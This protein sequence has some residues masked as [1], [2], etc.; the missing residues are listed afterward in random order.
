MHG[1][2]LMSFDKVLKE[3]EVDYIINEEFNKDCIYNSD[4]GWFDYMVLGGRFRGY[5][6]LEY[7]RYK[8]GQIPNILY[9]LLDYEYTKTVG[10]S[11]KYIANIIKGLYP[12]EK[13]D[14]LKYSKNVIPYNKELM[15]TFFEA[16]NFS[17]LHKT[18]EV[19][20]TN[21]YRLDKLKVSDEKLLQLPDGAF[22][23][24]IVDY[25]H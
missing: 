16:D 10:I 17:Q 20:G 8:Y 6:V 22:N 1:I 23:I 15:K 5:I 19:F 21:I 9:E 3:Y 25:H 12:N 14:I 18:N 4:E 7:L 24:A 11:K 13:I 2:L